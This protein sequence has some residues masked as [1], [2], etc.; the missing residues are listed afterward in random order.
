MAIFKILKNLSLK[1][2]IVSFL[3][4]LLFLYILGPETKKVFVYPNP[5][6]VGKA[7]FQDKTNQCFS[8]REEAV[9]CPNDKKDISTIPVQ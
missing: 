2:F 7:I 1:I 9:M 4:G 5:E 8:Y 6:T 3:V